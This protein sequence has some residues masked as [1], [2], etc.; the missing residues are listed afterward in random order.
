MQLADA[1][2]SERPL[3]SER[4]R[5]FESA[6]LHRRVECEPASL[7]AQPVEMGSIEPV[8]RGPAL[9]PVAHVET[10]STIGWPDVAGDAL[11]QH[12]YDR[13]SN[14][15]IDPSGHI[16]KDKDKR[17]TIGVAGGLVRWRMN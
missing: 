1:R 10:I 12:C 2:V 11:R 14:V 6:F 16:R 13:R 3:F 4:D 9:Q 8:H 5:W 15:R 7:T 17:Y